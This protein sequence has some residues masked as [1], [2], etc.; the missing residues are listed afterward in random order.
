MTAKVLIYPSKFDNSPAE[1]FDI[2]VGQTLNEW[3]FKNVPAYFISDTPLF[4]VILNDSFL[5]MEQWDT[6]VI[7]NNDVLKLT[8]EAKGPAEW[9]LAIVAVIAI[10]ISIYAM[11]QIPDSYNKTNTPTASSI[12]NV[13]AQGNQPRLMGIIPEI[14]GR[15]KIFPDYLNMPR[16]E[17]ID[18]EQFLYLMLAVGVGEYEINYDEIYISDT[19]VSGYEGDIDLQIFGPGENVSIHEAHRNVYTSDEVGSTAGTSGI[20]LRGRLWSAGDTDGGYRWN[21]SGNQV[22]TYRLDYRGQDGDPPRYMQMNFPFEENDLVNFFGTELNDGNYRV[23]SI[24]GYS[25][26]FH[27]LNSSAGDDSTW[28]N[29]ES[30]SQVSARLSKIGVGDSGMYNGPFYACPENEKT[31]KV[32][33]DFFLPNG[34]GELTDEGNFINRTVQIRV[35]HRDLDGGEWKYINHYF[36][37]ETNDQLAE[38]LEIEFDTKIRPEVKIQR[39]TSEVDSTRINDKITWTGLKSEL[40]TAT[41]YPDVTTIAVKIRGTNALAR[42]AEN[43][44]N[45]IGTRILPVYENGAWQSPK[46]TTDIAPFFSYIIKD[47]GHSDD[48]IGLT[49]LERLHNTW[50]SRD[51]T[52]SA[53]FDGES[54]LFASLKRVLAVG[55]SEPTLDYGQIIPVRDEPR[56]AWEYM[57]QPDNMLDKGLERSTNLIS[58][59][60]NDGVEVEYFSD[61]TWTSET[62]LCLLPED[63]G[64]NPKKVR[65]YGI[66]D[67]T[68][69]WQFGMRQRR[70]M[71][72]RRTQYSFKTE[73]DALNSRYLSYCA[74]AD[75]IP[76]Y[77]QTGKLERAAST[78][79]LTVDQPLEW[80]VGTHYF[81]LRKPNGTLSGP[82]IVTAG[83]DEYSVSTDRPIDFMPLL[84]GSQEPPLFMFGSAERWCYPALITDISPQGTETVSV[85]A[86]NYDPRVYED[87]NNNPPS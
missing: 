57:Y 39:V 21:L 46:P 3:L 27:R 15:H 63:E 28:S 42:S 45:L 16:R 70:V 43:K 5:N 37:G 53:V 84:D 78:H 23:V 19:P 85:K 60:E 18:N 56:V 49:E 35:A 77:S 68:K 61:Q 65:A 80:G 44:F 75:D 86:V 6:W 48:Q 71:R 29:F 83:L 79:Y 26:V 36:S 9:A 11:N 1:V 82:Y 7:Q 64:I 58:D 33:L 87:D 34:I 50:Q 67:A 55:F 13:N 47:V 51:D 32:W 24:N 76:G 73:M 66:T 17:Y 10:A 62:V 4:S 72:Y 38:T 31:D 54:T 8:V 40:E 14:A 25:A 22:F 74:L 41:S 52:F 12:Y 30:E 59:D 69:A 20:E 2:E 81:A